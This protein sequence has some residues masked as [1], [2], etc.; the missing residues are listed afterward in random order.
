MEVETQL[1]HGDGVGGRVRWRA[2]TM[3]Q[4]SSAWTLAQKGGF[5]GKIVMLPF[6]A[7]VVPTTSPKRQHEVG[8]A[9]GCVGLGG[10]VVG[11]DDRS[12]EGEAGRLHQAWD[13]GLRARHPLLVG[14]Q[15]GRGLEGGQ[16]GGDGGVE[17]LRDIGH[18]A[19]C[20]PRWGPG[21]YDTRRCGTGRCGR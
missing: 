1:G 16:R 4:L 10:V 5:Q 18:G 12:H 6:G 19:S 11:A 9:A 15:G 21:A 14:L 8:A 13:V 17:D 20:G 3:E 2:C 7:P